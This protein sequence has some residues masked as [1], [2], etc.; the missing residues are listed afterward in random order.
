MFLAFYE[1]QLI[2]VR[3]QSEE[4]RGA[5][6]LAKAD[7]SP[8][9]MFQ[10][11][12]QMDAR[13]ARTLTAGGILTLEELAYVPIGELLG[14][15]GLGETDAQLYRKRARQYLLGDAIGDSGDEGTID[16]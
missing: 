16:A 14:V 13:L 2:Q 15:Q 12:L 1:W 9:A 4:S 7:E 10:R 3:H 11:T 6:H 5:P 8:E